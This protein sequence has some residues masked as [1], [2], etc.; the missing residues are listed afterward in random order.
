MNIKFNT[1][2][3]LGQFVYLRSDPRQQPWMIV[4]ISARI[5][6]SVL[7]TITLGT[8]AYHAYEQELSAE[9]NELIAAGVEK[10]S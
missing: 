9:R 2:Y 10:T 8:A 5:D 7:Y 3:K 1:P 4:S 6:G